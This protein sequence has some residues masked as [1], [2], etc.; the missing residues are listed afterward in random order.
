MARGEEDEEEEMTEGEWYGVW[1]EGV[2]M[3]VEEGGR[4]G[5][6]DYSV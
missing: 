5:F 4:N 2:G 6:W 1:E 3:C